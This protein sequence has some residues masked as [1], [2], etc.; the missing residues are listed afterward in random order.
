MRRYVVYAVGS[1]ICLL[2]AVNM[3]SISVAFPDIMAHFDVSL[4]VVGWVV[5]AFNLAITAN[6]PLAGKISDVLGRKGSFLGF[7]AIFTGGSVLATF[8]P[9][10]GVLIVARLIQG[11]GGSGF[12]PC[13]TGIIADEFP[14]S[15]Q[16]AIGLLAAVF[17]VGWIL[18]PNIGALLVTIYGYQSI[19]WMNIPLCII[20]FGLSVFIIPGK[21]RR[22][23]H[24]DVIGAAL[25]AFTL[26]FFMVGLSELDASRGGIPWLLVIPLFAAGAVSLILFLKR[27]KTVKEPILEPEVL[28]SKPFMSANLFNFMFGAVFGLATFIPFYAVS[29]Y[30]MSTLE[31]GLIITPR[32]VGVFLTSLVTSLFLVRWGYRRPMLIGSLMLLPAMLLLGLEFPGFSNPAVVMM[33]FIGFSGLGEG[34]VVPAANNACIELMPHRISTITAVRT[35]FR[36]AGNLFMVTIGALL[37]HD[38]G[39]EAGFRLLFWGFAAVFIVVAMPMIF[40][41]PNSAAETCAV[42]KPPG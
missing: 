31:S 19:F 30:G 5:S 10:I 8:A 26:L 21:E 40:L 27:Q 14:Q 42:S 17:P 32:S 25:M 7:M 33:A 18:G 2:Q 28:R 23:A 4:I 11:I 15:R 39:T 20:C 36:Q 35:M 6:V 13:V 9:N 29:V 41:M 12:V 22:A 16:K 1:L 24:L 37:L 38:F 3:T 34:A